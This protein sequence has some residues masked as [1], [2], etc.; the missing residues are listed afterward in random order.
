MVFNELLSI[1]T[2]DYLLIDPNQLRH[3]HSNVQDNPFC[4]EPMHIDSPE[5]NLV[6]SVQS[7]GT[8]IFLNTWTPSRRELETL[9]HV[10]LMSPYPWVPQNVKIPEFSDSLQEEVEIR[11]FVG[12]SIL[13]YNLTFEFLDSNNCRELHGF[14][15][16]KGFP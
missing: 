4:G 1:P 7:E 16:I 12:V 2:L 9:T 11:G 14:C 15:D 8:C 6:S 3:H 5:E 13:Q 10:V